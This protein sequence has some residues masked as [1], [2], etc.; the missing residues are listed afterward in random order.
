MEGWRADFDAGGFAA[1][2]PLLSVG[3]TGDYDIGFDFEREQEVW[4]GR[5]GLPEVT[6]E[7]VVRGA[8]ELAGRA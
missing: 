8:V 5:L 7:E 2:V 4:N 6:L 3:F 1:T